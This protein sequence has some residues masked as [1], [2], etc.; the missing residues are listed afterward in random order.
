MCNAYILTNNSLTMIIDNTPHT[1]PTSHHNFDKIMSELSRG[2]YSNILSLISGN[3]RIL[4][5]YITSIRGDVVFDCTTD[6][7]TYKD[8]IVHDTIVEKIVEFAQKSLPIQPLINFLENLYDNPSCTAIDELYLFLEYGRLPITED[9]CFIAY[10][11]VND[12]YTSVYDKKTKNNIGLVVEMP[13]NRV[14]DDRHQTC[15]TGLHFCSYDYISEIKG[16]RIVLLKINPADVVSIPID[17]N[18]TKGRACKYTVVGELT[19]EKKLPLSETTYYQ[20]DTINTISEEIE[21]LEETNNVDDQGDDEKALIEAYHLGYKHGRTK[22]PMNVNITSNTP[23]KESDM[24]ILG[25][26]HGKLH[27]RKQY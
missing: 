23:L 26:K 16:D 5:N 17:Y 13:R 9:G 3:K 19:H 22:V 8:K 6:K 24:Y 25:Y 27:K 10:K 4:S 20:F 15:S 18:N 11:V 12:D 7:I 2:E 14:N 21:D 1:I